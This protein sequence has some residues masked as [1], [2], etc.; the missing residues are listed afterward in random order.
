VNAT[1]SAWARGIDM[2]YYRKAT[3]KNNYISAALQSE[4]KPKEA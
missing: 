2:Y 1:K 3:K 4:G